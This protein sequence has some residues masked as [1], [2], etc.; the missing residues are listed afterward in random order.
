MKKLLRLAGGSRLTFILLLVNVLI[1]GRASATHMAGADLTYTYLGNNQYEITYTFY[2]DCIG[3][4]AQTSISLAYGSVTCGFSN[5]ATLLPVPGTG[6]QITHVCPW[7]TTTCDG[8]TA[9]GIQEWEYTGIVTLPAACPDWIFSTEECCRNAAITTIVDPD[10]NQMHLDATLNNTVSNNN[11]AVFSNI[12]IA[13]ECIGQDNYFNHGGFD[14]DGDSLVYS[15]VTPMNQ[16]NLPVVFNSGYTFNNPLTSVPPVSVDPMTGD[17]FMHPTTPEVAIMAVQIQEYRNGVLIGTVIRDI[18]VYVIQCNNNLPAMSGINGTPDFSTSTCA[19]SPVCFDLFSSDVD[20]NDSL[21]VTWN[22][23]IP[24]G[25]FSAPV[26]STR[27]TGHF[28]WTP[29]AADVRP[30]PW[31]FTV[32]VQDNACPVN[33]E[34]TFSYSILVSELSAT[35]TSTDVSC[36]GGH[37]GSA[38]ISPQGQGPFEV[39]WLPGEFTNTHITHLSA[40]TYNVL[41]TNSQGCSVSQTVVINEPPALVV[42]T[43][44][45]D[46]NCSGQLAAGS[47]SVTGGTGAYA[48]SWNTNPVQTT[49]SISN[50]SPGTYIV[51]VTDD[52]HCTATDSITVAGSSGF[53][54]TLQTSPATCLAS[55]GSATVTVNGGSGNFSYDWQPAVSQSNTASNLAAGYYSVTVTDITGGCSQTLS[56]I[57]HGSTGIVA[58]ILSH[59]DATC[60]SSEDGSAIAT[61]SGGNPPYDY[62][63]MP[64][65]STDSSVS[66]LSPGTYVLEVADYLGCPDYDTVTIGYQFA[67]PLIDLGND[68]TICAGDSIILDAGSGY[69]Y[70][71]QDNSTDQFFTANADGV[72]SV[73]ITDNNGCQAYDAIQVTTIGCQ[74]GEKSTSNSGDAIVFPNPAHDEIQ[75]SFQN[76]TPEEVSISV[77]DSFGRKCYFSNENLKSFGTKKI[78]LKEF[79]AGLYYLNITSA[80]ESKSI[81]FVVE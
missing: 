46:G 4:P 19:G 71:W 73:L 26:T 1:A 39:V 28:C 78:S 64:G 49:S 10:N 6:Q 60:Q 14:A 58:T 35:T 25:S 61:A 23:G 2:R 43:T 53:T 41:A 75:I 59:T 51:T 17:I 72:Y 33:G 62:L 7:A 66:N 56:G 38:T 50:L 44:S 69:Q 3:I 65:G 34:Q 24:S 16:S 63:W 79:A 77:Y 30:N 32:N 36:N 67:S 57:V 13:F 55:D 22:S 74:A 81:P 18:Q 54:A 80:Q 76:K 21:T 40:G 9:T 45:Q 48:Y 15:L 8:G 20:T 70:L 47:C 27:P 12:P 52:H 11:S 68:T 5:V 42:T 31:I 37:N 29:T